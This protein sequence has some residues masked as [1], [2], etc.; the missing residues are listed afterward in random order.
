MMRSATRSGRTERMQNELTNLLPPE[1]QRAR[2]RAYVMRACVVGIVLV[3]ALMFT[4]TVL[5]AP[6]YVLLTKSA[7]AKEARLA[8]M[9]SALSSGDERELSARLTALTKDAAALTALRDI[10]SASGMAR[11]VLA[12]ARPGVTLSGF[13]YAPATD[14]KERTFSVSGIAAT[15]DALRNYQLALQSAPF[16]RSATLPISAYAKDTDIAFT[17]TIMLVPRREGLA[18]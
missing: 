7:S 1:R 15:R 11:S 9:E 13:A 5:L 16:A 17:I 3:S 14:K 6:A 10:P 4:A 12:I 18:L 8:S 2:A